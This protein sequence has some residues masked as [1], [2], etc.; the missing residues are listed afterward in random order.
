LVFGYI[1]LTEKENIVEVL[2]LS[3]YKEISFNIGETKPI[4]L[5]K[6]EVEKIKLKHIGNFKISKTKYQKI[7]DKDSLHLEILNLWS[8]NL[9]KR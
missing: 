9:R 7:K 3:Y 4:L 5:S 8:S 1:H 6:N 2:R